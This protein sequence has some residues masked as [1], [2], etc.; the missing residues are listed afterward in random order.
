MISKLRMQYLIELTKKIKQIDIKSYTEFSEALKIKIKQKKTI[1]SCG[2]GGSAS[3]A[4]HF[5]CDFNKRIKIDIPRFISL[6]NN[7][8]IITAISNDISYENIF[9]AQLNNLFQKENSI[10]CISS[11]GMSKNIINAANYVKNHNGTV[12]S[13]TGFNGGDLREISDF[14]IH[15]DSTVYGIVEDCH[16]II[17]H[18]LVND[19]LNE[20]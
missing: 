9:D 6:V 8:E 20:V 15:I 7:I 3:I 17:M 4:N 12:F 14:N 1:F 13:L 2:N 11:S 5:V 19:F 18:S 10:I 16:Q